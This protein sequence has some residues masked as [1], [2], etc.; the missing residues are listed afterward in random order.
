MSTSTSAD[1]YYGD[2][3]LF[4]FDR[5]GKSSAPVAGLK[6]GPTHDFCWSPACDS[7]VVISGKS[8]PLTT[9]HNK[10]GAATF[11]FG[12]A[13]FNTALKLQLLLEPISYKVWCGRSLVVCMCARRDLV[14]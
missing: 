11:S 8:P 10:A 4:L 6:D 1:N 14:C 3:R 12:T 13:A 2:S 5:S 7:F 9:L